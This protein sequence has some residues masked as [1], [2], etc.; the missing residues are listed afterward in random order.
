[1]GFVL[2]WLALALPLSSFVAGNAGEQLVLHR[3]GVAL[4]LIGVLAS[5]A[6]FLAGRRGGS[7]ARDRLAATLA[8]ALYLFF[9]FHEFAPLVGGTERGSTYALWLVLFAIV[10]A[11]V[12]LLARR[13]VVPRYLALVAGL[14]VAANVVVAVAGGTG[15]AAVPDSTAAVPFDATTTRTGATPDVYYFVV[16][17]YGRADV[18]EEVVDVDNRAFLDQ[19]R[20]RGLGVSERAVSN[21]PLTFLSVA[22]TLDMDYLLTDGEPWSDRAPFY[23]RLGGSNATVAGFR[24]LG[25]RYVHAPG[26]IWGGSACGDDVDVCVEPDRFL[27]ET[28]WAF[29]RRTPIADAVAARFEERVVKQHV[30]PGAVVDAVLRLRGDQPTFTFAH[31]MSPHPPYVRTADCGTTTQVEQD[32]EAWGDEARP[33]Y[34]GALRCLNRQLLDA[35]DRILADDPDA[36]IVVQGDHGSSFLSPWNRRPQRWP[37]DAVTE[38]FAIL[39]AVRPPAGCAPAPDDLT[40]VNTFRLIFSCLTGDPIPLLPN[41]AYAATYRPR[42]P[43]VDV[44]GVLRLPTPGK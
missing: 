44:S 8:V 41:R 35:V 42:E 26:G 21:Y 19:L 37:E 13:A 25:Y 40:P 7:A 9:H 23:E 43:L 22:S 17:A 2:V 39:S 14:L 12:A 18:L 30:E 15:S 31:V 38:R 24:Q 16:D 34:S 3:I 10:V 5:V 32:L 33:L 36:V 20:S 1:M 28:E 6:V 4:G 11:G 29:L 27:D